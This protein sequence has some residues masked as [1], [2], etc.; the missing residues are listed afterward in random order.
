MLDADRLNQ[1]YHAGLRW[2][3]ALATILYG[4]IIAILGLIAC[5]RLP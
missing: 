5:L 1:E 4:V 3:F 2:G